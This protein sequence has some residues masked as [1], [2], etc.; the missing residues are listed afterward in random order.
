MIV[1]DKQNV[2]G[3]VE[4]RPSDLRWGAPT[5][6]DCLP[7]LAELCNY[8]QISRQTISRAVGAYMSGMYP[9]PYPL[10]RRYVLDLDTAVRSNALAASLAFNPDLDASTRS[11]AIRAAILMARP[12]RRKL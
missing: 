5:G 2:K 6:D 1:G 9:S 7:D 11:A 10:G 12:D 8:R 4:D 3:Q